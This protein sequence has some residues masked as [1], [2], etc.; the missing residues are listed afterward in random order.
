MVTV[1]FALYEAFEKC[2]SVTMVASAL[3]LPTRFVA[4]RVEAARLTLII[5]NGTV[6]SATLTT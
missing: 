4:E 5:L 1:S 2:G 3:G 6:M